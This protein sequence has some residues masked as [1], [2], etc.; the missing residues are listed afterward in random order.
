MGFLVFLAEDSEVH[1]V[2]MEH[3]VSMF[4]FDQNDAVV[5]LGD[6]SSS[7]LWPFS[8]LD[9]SSEVYFLAR[10]PRLLDG[11]DRNVL[12]VDCSFLLRVVFLLPIDAFSNLD[13]CFFML[14]F[15]L[16]T[17]VAPFPVYFAVFLLLLLVNSVRFGLF[18]S[19]LNDSDFLHVDLRVFGQLSKFASTHHDPLLLFPFYFF[20]RCLNWLAADSLTSLTF[21]RLDFCG[22]FLNH[23]FGLAF[24]LSIALH[25]ASQDILDNKGSF[26]HPR[27]V[28]VMP[29]ESVHSNLSH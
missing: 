11:F 9:P 14:F 27:P 13:W 19:V 4:S 10:L 21:F 24:R 5:F 8:E 15:L 3:S 18:F 25:I 16:I 6:Y 1:F 7:E 2:V 20:S 28:F 17:L 22:N 23:L 26:L 29:H 12:I